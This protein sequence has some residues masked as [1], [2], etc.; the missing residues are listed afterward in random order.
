MSFIEKFYA[1]AREF[2]I[3]REGQEGVYLLYLQS[4]GVLI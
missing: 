4:I 1:I 3:I 2:T